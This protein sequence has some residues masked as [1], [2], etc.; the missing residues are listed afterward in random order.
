MNIQPT[1]PSPPVKTEN[2]TVKTTLSNLMKSAFQ[3]KHPAAMAPLSQQFVRAGNSTATMHKVRPGDIAHPRKSIEVRY[4][5]DVKQHLT[6]VRMHQRTNS[7]GETSFI[8]QP[9]PLP[10]ITLTDVSQSTSDLFTEAG[11]TAK[12]PAKR[13]KLD[14]DP[15]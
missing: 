7:I 3:V 5:K 4:T 12:L 14:I 2:K 1:A 8:E 9:L 11:N 10:R 6:G 15:R 13:N